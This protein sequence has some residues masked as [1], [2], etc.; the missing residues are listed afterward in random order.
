MGD[1]R[2]GFAGRRLG[3]TATSISNLIGLSLSNVSR[4]HQSGLLKLRSDPGFVMYNSKVIDLYNEHE[5][6]TNKQA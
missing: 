2:R 5:E 4:R 3:A 6:S 1:S